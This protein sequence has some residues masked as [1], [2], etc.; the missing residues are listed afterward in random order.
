LQR[1]FAVHCPDPSTVL[2][3]LKNKLHSQIVWGVL[4]T[5]EWIKVFDQDQVAVTAPA[6]VVEVEA[7]A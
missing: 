4:T 1:I 7:M 5:C 6:N 2:L 3:A